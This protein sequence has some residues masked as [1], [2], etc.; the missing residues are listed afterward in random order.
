MVSFIEIAKMFFACNIPFSVTE[1][2]QLCRVIQ[3]LRPGYTPPSSKAISGILLDNVH[4]KL[5]QDM[6]ASV[7]GK[8]ATRTSLIV[9]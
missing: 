6:K 7:M 2:P 3:L 1:H 9:L 4:D 8:T 5:T